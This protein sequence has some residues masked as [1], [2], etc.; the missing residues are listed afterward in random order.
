MPT[1]DSPPKADSLPPGTP[2]LAKWN[3]V[4]TCFGKRFTI[5]ND[6]FNIRHTYE[7]SDEDKNFMVSFYRIMESLLAEDKI[8]VM[9][10][11]IKQGGLESVL[12][13]VK[14]VREGKVRAKKLVYPLL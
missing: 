9:P 8:R 7:A 3:F 1:S 5:I 12:D 2:I 10:H 6:T 13:G 11:E 14:L 4:Y